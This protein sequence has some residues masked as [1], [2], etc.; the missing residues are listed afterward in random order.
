[1]RHISAQKVYDN[2]Q[3]STRDL[4]NPKQME[5]HPSNS[6]TSHNGN[7]SDDK[8]FQELAKP[9]RFFFFFN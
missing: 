7:I 6:C 4:L 3:H 8:I 1:M 2:H 9:I 5:H